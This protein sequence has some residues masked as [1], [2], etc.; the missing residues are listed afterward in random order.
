MPFKIDDNKS[1]IN[2]TASKRNQN[3]KTNKRRKRMVLK[4]ETGKRK[5]AMK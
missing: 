3:N 1:K 5:D 2:N 4:N